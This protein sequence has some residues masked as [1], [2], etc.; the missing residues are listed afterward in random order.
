MR[1]LVLSLYYWPDELGI[2]RVST[3]RCE[4]L[5][6]KG[7]QVTVC[8]GHPFYPEWRIRGKGLHFYQREMR[9]AVTI[10]RSPIYVPRRASSARRILHEASFIASSTVSAIRNR[11]PDLIMVISP[12]LGLGMP[13]MALSRLWGIPYIF[14]VE[15]LQPDAAIDLGMLQSGP[16][17][18]ALLRLE[19]VCYR[20]AAMVTT[21]NEAMRAR[22]IAKGIEAQKVRL[23][24]HWCDSSLFD[25]P[26][27]A[28]DAFRQK[29]GIDKDT[30]LVSHSGNMGVKQGLE[31]VLNAARMTGDDR[32]VLYLLV[33]DG[34]ARQQLEE[35][36]VSRK[37][38]NL[39]FLP[40]LARED[41]TG[42]LAAS[43]ITLVTQLKTVSDIVFPSKVETLLAAGR[44][45]VASVNR[46]S[47]VA[48]LLESAHAG[49][50]VTPE[51]PKALAAAIGSIKR[52]RAAA[53]TIAENGRRYARDHWSVE[54]ILPDMEELLLEAT[55]APQLRGGLTQAAPDASVAE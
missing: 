34:A 7:H 40:V 29:Y 50:V 52:D 25:L 15:D 36:A 33:G 6:S 28:G 44:S 41:F 19:S 3:A 45:V 9:N 35:G 55:T 8:T 27:E 37:L 16:L 49:I 46:Q 23:L 14:H 1:I 2:A 38:K 4:F 10:L 5:A 17:L 42:L 31:V 43:Q 13:T 54:R 48:R 26:C 21:L 11:R 24:S 30:F 32:E 53:N 39:R 18:R 22:I 20:K 47:S 51:D 12:P